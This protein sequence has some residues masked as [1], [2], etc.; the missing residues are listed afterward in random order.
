MAPITTAGYTRHTAL[1]HRRLHMI[2]CVCM[3]DA[4][5]ASPGASC[6]FRTGEGPSS[7]RLPPPNGAEAFPRGHATELGQLVVTV[8]LAE[9]PIVALRR[10]RFDGLLTNG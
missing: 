7:H 3:T 8:C 5:S 9:F 1:S 4:Q 10:H 2:G 6:V